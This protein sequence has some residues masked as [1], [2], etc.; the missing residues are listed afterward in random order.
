MNRIKIWI[1]IFLSIF[2][3]GMF[4]R[5]FGEEFGDDE[6][7]NIIKKMVFAQGHYRYMGDIV[8]QS[9]L[10]ERPQIFRKKI[11]VDPPDRIRDE[12]IFP[13]KERSIIRILNGENFERIM[14]EE[15]IFLERRRRFGTQVPFL[16]R[17]KDNFNINIEDGGIIA[18]RKTN[19][20]AVKSKMKE[21]LSF[22]YWIDK[23]TGIILKKMVLRSDN[24]NLIP[25]YEKYFTHIDY[26]PP[27]KPDLFLIE[28]DKIKKMPFP[29]RETEE[30]KTIEQV[31][32]N[33]RFPLFTPTII[34]EG[35]ALDRIR[36]TREMNNITIH[37]NYSNGITS[38]SIFQSM[39]P[40]PLFFRKI[41]QEQ[42]KSG[43]EV[44]AF[45]RETRSIFFKKLGP[46]NLTLI[47]NCPKEILESVIVNIA[48]IK[49]SEN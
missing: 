38:F 49:K 22:N 32:E 30:Y 33:I 15:H 36:V 25:M 47:G 24:G 40:I 2:L 11:W 31:R 8:I 6:I 41:Y 28:K 18:E 42:K 12:L 37:L 29:K 19:L 13:D 21:R 9:F 45:E 39:G 4:I 43:D 3:S 34:P 17:I 16:K 7:D 23:E 48:P 46:F 1:F 26:K 27:I 20:I 5:G 10:G 44:I 14:D 35:Y